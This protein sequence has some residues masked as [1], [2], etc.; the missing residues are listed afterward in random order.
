[1]VA[2]S[3]TRDLDGDIRRVAQSQR[4]VRAM[5]LLSGNTSRP[6]SP[7]TNVAAE[8]EL[9]AACRALDASFVARNHDARQFRLALFPRE[10]PAAG[11]QDAGCRLVACNVPQALSALDAVSACLGSGGRLRGGA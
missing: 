3:G 7:G 4:A 8:I 5:G 10:L 6:A 11:R 1:M 9:G 2:K